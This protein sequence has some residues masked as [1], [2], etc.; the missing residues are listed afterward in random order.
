[1]WGFL[2]Y[3]VVLTKDDGVENVYSRNQHWNVWHQFNFGLLFSQ[4]VS[5]ESN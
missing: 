5:I 1:M 3:Q 2:S 4:I